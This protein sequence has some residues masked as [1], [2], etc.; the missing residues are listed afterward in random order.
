MRTLNA[1][2]RELASADVH[3]TLTCGLMRC[4]EYRRHPDP[5]AS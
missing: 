1:S 4:L 5:E 2:K 3:I